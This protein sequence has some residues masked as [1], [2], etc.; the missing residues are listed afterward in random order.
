MPGIN[1]TFTRSTG[2]IYNGELIKITNQR[3]NNSQNETMNVQ[4]L[5]VDS[6]AHSGEQSAGIL[7]KDAHRRLATPQSLVPL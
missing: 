7:E 6:R 4:E 1:A 3:E 2:Y 5:A